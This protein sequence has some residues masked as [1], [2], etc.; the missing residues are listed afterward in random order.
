[1][2]KQRIGTNWARHDPILTKATAIGRWP[3]TRPEAGAA[4]GVA[5]AGDGKARLG[6]ELAGDCMCKE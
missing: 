5:K 4:N 1:L 2:E 3:A 6:L